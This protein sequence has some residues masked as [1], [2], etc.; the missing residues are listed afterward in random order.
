[1]RLID[2]DELEEKAWR[3]G[4]GTRE[5]VANLIRNAPTV[6]AV[7]VVRCKDCYYCATEKS[8][9]KEYLYCDAFYEHAD[10]DLI[11][12]SLMV[13]PNHFCSWG[14]RREDEID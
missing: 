2:A 8:F 11:G 1:M 13:E 4:L 6:D 12:A 5:D 10:G 7:E 14:E 9:G 3:F